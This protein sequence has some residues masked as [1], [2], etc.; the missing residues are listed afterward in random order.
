[1]NRRNAGTKQ[2]ALAAL[3]SGVLCAPTARA[4]DAEVDMSVDAQFYM[5]KSP[6]GDPEVRYRRYTH[7]LGLSVYDI[8]GQDPEGGPTLTFRSRLRLDADFGIEPAE[9]DPNRSDRF[10]PALRRSPL[11]LMYAYLEG[12]GYLGGYLGF[13]AGRQYVVDAL[14]W[15]SF[16][17]AALSVTTPFFLRLEAYTGFEQRE[18]L[19]M[20]GTERF[21]ADGVYRGDRSGME[22]SQRPEYLRE[23]KLAPALGVALESTD[24]HWLHARLS[25]RRV[26][27]SD[28]VIVSPFGDA[29][30]GFVRAHGARISSERIGYAA[31]VNDTDLGAI[32]ARAVYD[33]YSQLFS[34]YALGADWYAGDELTV[35]A[36]ADYYV[37]TYDADSIFNWFG[38]TGTTS[39]LGRVEIAPTPRLDTT[40]STGVRL[41]STQ[42]EGPGTLLDYVAD[43]SAR[44]LVGDGSVAVR[45]L[46][47]A[48]QRGH[49]LGADVTGRQS[50]DAGFYDTLAVVSV[51]DWFDELRP[52]RDATSV[53][54]VLG[55][56][57]RPG[58]SFF[59]ESRIGVE[60]E[61]T[62][63]RL[64]GNRFRILATLDLTMF[65]KAR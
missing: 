24:L 56:G 49:L 26:I 37:P 46:A 20:L 58:G 48:G 33:L 30:G 6:F 15:W 53:G 12:Q 50:F 31:R 23:D 44:Y 65:R 18:G 61:H 64:V 2:W 45:G 13:R 28:T 16:D 27:Q 5:L 47:E 10:V 29:G 62:L 34:E 7:T 3:S 60:W 35:G 55:A 8:D 41:F 32:H 40:L 1:M 43:A 9:V 51:Y 42:D 14:G 39:V 38:Q 57:M 54:Y 4:Y 11:D 19:P 22:Y 63:N 25:Y 52:S 59:A 17:G 21:T 36:D